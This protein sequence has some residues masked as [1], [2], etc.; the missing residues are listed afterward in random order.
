MCGEPGKNQVEAGEMNSPGS[1]TTSVMIPYFEPYR[2]DN[3][4]VSNRN[5]A[6]SESAR[7]DWFPTTDGYQEVHLHEVRG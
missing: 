5:Y 4:P 6:I 7:G 3:L 1:P 2:S